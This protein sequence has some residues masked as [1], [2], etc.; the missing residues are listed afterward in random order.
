MSGRPLVIEP[1]TANDLP[2]ELRIERSAFPTPWTEAN[3][4]HEL[5]DNPLAWNLV[6]RS[7]GAVLAFACAY[8]V[9]GELMINDLAVDAAA[10]RSG[11]GR[12]LLRHLIDGARLRGCRRATLEVR[13]SNVAARALYASFAFSIVGRRPGYYADTGEDGLLL[14]RDL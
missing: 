6:A 12:E 11:I 10:R 3:F 9:A 13:P 1:M 8:V 14:A 2:A 5:A 7:G 4:R